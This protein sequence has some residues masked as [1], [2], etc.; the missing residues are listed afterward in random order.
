MNAHHTEK[1]TDNRQAALQGSMKGAFVKSSIF[2]GIIFLVALF[3]I[4]FAAKEPLIIA[5]VSVE[6]VDIDELSHTNQKPP[7]KAEPKPIE[8]PK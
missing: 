2:H 3:G 1:R 5:P 6:L 8:K 4:P 7:P